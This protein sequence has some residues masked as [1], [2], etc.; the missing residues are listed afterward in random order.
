MHD[1]VILNPQGSSKV[2]E[3]QLQAIDFWDLEPD[4]VTLNHSSEIGQAMILDAFLQEDDVPPDLPPG[5]DSSADLEGGSFEKVG[6]D[7]T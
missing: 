5:G 4:Q 1:H 3:A 6:V 7:L 2:L